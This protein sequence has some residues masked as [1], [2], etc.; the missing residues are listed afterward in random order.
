MV[1]TQNAPISRSR[2]HDRH[3]DER[4]VSVSFGPV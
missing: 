1:P 3:R 2:K 4:L